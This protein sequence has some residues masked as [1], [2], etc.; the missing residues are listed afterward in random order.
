ML[1]LSP[2]ILKEIKAKREN[3]RQ[4]YEFAGT[5]IKR[6]GDQDHRPQNYYDQD[7]RR[8]DHDDPHAVSLY[9]RREGI[10]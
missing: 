1:A 8:R 5:Q 7:H 4:Q 3:Q 9:P 2:S 10:L 6:S